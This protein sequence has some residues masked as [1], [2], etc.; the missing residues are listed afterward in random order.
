MRELFNDR[1]YFSQFGDSEVQDQGA[2]KILFGG[3]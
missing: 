3:W 1:I 2:G